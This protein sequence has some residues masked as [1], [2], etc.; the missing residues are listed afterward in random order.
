MRRCVVL[1]SDLPAFQ[2]VVAQL[3]AVCAK[4]PGADA[5]PALFRLL[6]R[7]DF[8]D[9]ARAADVWAQGHKFFPTAADWIAAVRTVPK[10]EPLLQMSAEET[11]EW[12][13]AEQS[14]YESEPCCCRE[15]TAAGVTDLPIR[16]V[17]TEDRFGE[18]EKRVIGSRE[19]LRGH[20][21][22]G[23][24]LGRWY[25]AKTAFYKRFYEIFPNAKRTTMADSLLG[26][27]L[28]ALAGQR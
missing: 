7:Y 19:V 25:Q 16:F 24:E 26:P 17:P 20:W 4:A 28:A 21:A 5:T 8:V 22:H 27:I 1:D 18:Y 13:H 11:S 9:V 2:R 3:A 23:Q 14:H 6:Q 15:C 10:G 12:L